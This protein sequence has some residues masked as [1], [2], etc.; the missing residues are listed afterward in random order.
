MLNTF[1]GRSQTGRTELV[2]QG[3]TS[4][5]ITKG[6]W[7]YIVPNRGEPLNK[8][9]NIETGNSKESQLYDLKVDP[10]EKN[11]LAKQYPG[12]VKELAALLE[13]IKNKK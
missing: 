10:S 3:I 12:K 8:L 11:N 5:T 13:S 6:R 1:L 7:K 4:L 9:V 2:K